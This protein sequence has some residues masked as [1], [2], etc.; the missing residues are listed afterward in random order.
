[1]TAPNDLID[2]TA[3]PPPGTV[4]PKAP[5]FS[6]NQQQKAAVVVR[7]LLE[8]GSDI[9]LSDLPVDLQVQLT[10]LMGQ[11]QP[12]DRTTLAQVVA[13][14]A[15]ELEQLGVTFPRDLSAALQLMEDR[16]TPRSVAQLR[17]Q[18]GIRQDGDPWQR[19]NTLT[20]EELIEVLEAESSE[21]SAVILSKVET[22]LAAKVLS[23]LPG[24]V[25]RRLSYALSK[26]RNVT[27]EAV[28]RIGFSLIGQLDNKPERAFKDD[29]EKRLGEILNLSNSATREDLLNGLIAEDAQFGTEVRRNIFTFQDIVDRLA[30]LDVPKLVKEVDPEQLVTALAAAPTQGLGHVSEF[31]LS[32]MSNRMAANLQEEI[33]EAPPPDPTDAE[34]AMNAVILALKSLQ[35]RGEIALRSQ[36]EDTIG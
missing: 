5:Q 8:E 2:L 36:K 23:V 15:E 34:A 26:T 21:I 22:E 12:V 31:L 29:P 32:H 33:S 14:F 35:S 27:P 6:L 7:F 25:A 11:M 17:K 16:I 9:H 1:M 3:V 18:A 30:P 28:D 4:H 20:P 13:E 10:T 19:I 24:E